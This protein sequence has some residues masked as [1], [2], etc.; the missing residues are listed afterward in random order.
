MLSPDKSM[1]CC[2]GDD[3]SAVILDAQS[4]ATITSLQGHLDYSYSCA[5][6]PDGLYV[7]TGN[8]D[9]TTRVYDI[10]APTKALH[11]LEAKM[12]AVR[13]CAFTEDGRFLVM[14]EPSDFVHVVDC[15]TY[16]R[17]QV[18]DMFGEIGG[19]AVS[20]DSQSL[21]IANA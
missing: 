20:P 6:S 15:A 16:G 19:V 7:A 14:V 17:K 11:V 3:T 12:G 13:R 10:R 2:A 18:I 5:W 1:I 4:G 9:K 21:F 8:Q